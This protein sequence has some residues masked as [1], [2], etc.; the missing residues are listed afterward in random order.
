MECRSK[1]CASLTC[2][3]I[4][5]KHWAL[6]SQPFLRYSIEDRQKD[7]FLTIKTLLRGRQAQVI[8]L[9]RRRV[10]II[11]KVFDPSLPVR[12]KVRRS[13]VRRRLF[14]TVM[15]L[16]VGRGISVAPRLRC[17]THWTV[18]ES[19]L[20]SAFSEIGEVQLV[21][22][23]GGPTR[24]R[25]QCD[26]LFAD[27]SA[28]AEALACELEVDGRLCRLSRT[29]TVD[30][31]RGHRELD[32]RRRR[33]YQ[34]VLTKAASDDR[35]PSALPIKAPANFPSRTAVLTAIE[36]L[37]LAGDL[38]HSSELATAVSALVAVDEIQRA[39]A[40]YE[41]RLSTE[42]S[43][44]ARGAGVT[45]LTA[46]GRHT[47]ALDL[48]MA[49]G[50]DLDSR[51]HNSAIISAEVVGDFDLAFSIL[52]RRASAANKVQASACFERE[53]LK[54]KRAWL[55]RDVSY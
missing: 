40:L 26:V 7:A 20:A 10:V 45:V 36:A 54:A 55:E 21:D 41:S 1:T 24:M 51:G 27:P 13:M 22:Y 9:Q 4:T 39:I 15:H 50:D 42:T 53:A 43:A 11:G 14:L 30:V 31:R 52:Q 33:A 32:P 18:T 34:S 19:S 37:D 12:L 38:K 25:T 49:A 47:D 23:L 2:I 48:A 29:H 5:K 3:Y 16:V 46:S 17:Q 44:A 35:G 28:A 6:W 8:Y